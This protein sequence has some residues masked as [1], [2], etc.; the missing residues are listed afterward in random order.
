MNRNHIFTSRLL[1]IVHVFVML[2]GAVILARGTAINSSAAQLSPIRQPTRISKRTFNSPLSR[3]RS[4]GL[5]E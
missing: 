5:N 2:I 3:H 1:I 4:I